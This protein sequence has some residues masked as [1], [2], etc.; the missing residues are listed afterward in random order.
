MPIMFKCNIGE[1]ACPNNLAPTTSTTAH[2]AMGD[3]LAVCLLNCVSFQ[4]KTLP[5]I[6]LGARWVN[7]FI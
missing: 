7:N 2:L 5:S 1:E 4:A 3:A 6:I